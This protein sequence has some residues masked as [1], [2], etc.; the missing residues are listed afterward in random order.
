MGSNAYLLF[1]FDKLILATIKLLL[2]FSNNE[3]SQKS[4]DLFGTFNKKTQS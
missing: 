3:E 2:K 4:L 1:V